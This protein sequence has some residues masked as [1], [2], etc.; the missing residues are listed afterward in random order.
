M[1]FL[2]LRSVSNFSTE[3]L[4]DP[5]VDDIQL[6]SLPLL[7]T[8]LLHLIFEF[9]QVPH[10][11]YCCFVSK[12]FNREV[13][14]FVSGNQFL[15][16][17]DLLP[18]EIRSH[19]S[20]TDDYIERW[21]HDF[22]I[23]DFIPIFKR[24]GPY[25]K[26]LRM[27]YDSCF[28]NCIEKWTETYMPLLEEIVLFSD[29]YYQDKHIRKSWTAYE[30]TWL[31]RKAQLKKLVVYGPVHY[32]VKKVLIGA[33]ETNP[34]I[35][36]VH[37]LY[38]DLGED[39]R[40]SEFNV[41]CMQPRVTTTEFNMRDVML[42]FLD[43][44][45][46]PYAA[47]EST[48]YEDILTMCKKFSREGPELLVEIA[49]RPDF[50]D[51]LAFPRLL[52]R[53]FDWKN[54]TE[55]VVKWVLKWIPVEMFP[56]MLEGLFK[57]DVCGE[58]DIKYCFEFL[59]KADRFSLGFS[60]ACRLVSVCT[61]PE[62][63]KGLVVNMQQFL[64][65]IGSDD[66]DEQG[67]SLLHFVQND[68]CAQILLS[69]ISNHCNDEERVQSMLSLRNIDSH[70]PFVK[71]LLRDQYIET[72]LPTDNGGTDDF[73]SNVDGQDLRERVEYLKTRFEA[74]KNQ[75]EDEDE[76]AWLDWIEMKKKSKMKEDKKRSKL[77]SKLRFWKR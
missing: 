33:L 10:L 1:K 28:Q 41:V 49:S 29:F 61:R 14:S 23:C 32:H 27:M 46:V 35:E 3:D 58:K 64:D 24:F 38:F 71:A 44:E 36:Q 22:A 47:F 19:P 17:L 73:L 67:N 20:A 30:E 59:E 76:K 57:S 50:W 4:N 70:T 34:N 40:I 54:R 9:I 48:F 16:I 7:P 77:L 18:R 62:Q 75:D 53:A 37:L 15:G 12:R 69:A 2:F 39:S 8:E 13:Q 56:Q 74:D 51:S 25:I 65:S 42:Y 45:C 31:A 43:K 26:T 72:L 5:F 60:L 52:R 6:L 68:S 55:D 63:M 11:Y 66:G 21:Y